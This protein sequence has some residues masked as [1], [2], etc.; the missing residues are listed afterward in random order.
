VSD[1]ERLAS[2]VETGLLDTAAEETFDRYTR[3]ATQL[4]NTPVS[5]VSLVDSDRQFFKSQVGLSEPWATARETPLSHSICKH[6]VERREPLLVE[7]T[8]SDP[9]F[10][11]NLAVSEL[12]VISYAGMPLTLKD[13][14]TIGTLCA[15]GPIPRRWTEED[16]GFLRDLATSLVSEIELRGEL[17]KRDRLQREMEGWL[18]FDRVLVEVSTRFIDTPPESIRSV[19]VS[20]LED[21]VR[22]FGGGGAFL[23]LEPLEGAGAREL[24]T[25]LMPDQ[26]QLPATG[27]REETE[28][29]L[30]ERLRR[31]ETVAIEDPGTLPPD[32]AGLRATLERRGTGAV[33]W[34]PVQRA[35]V[36]R[37]VLTLELRE[38]GQWAEHQL[39]LLRVFAERAYGAIRR[40][41]A[42]IE[43]AS[44]RA[45]AEA[46]MRAKERF[47]ANMSHELRTPLNAVIGVSQ[48]LTDTELDERQGDYLRAITHSARLLLALVNDLLDLARVDSGRIEFERVAFDFER[49]LRDAIAPFGYEAQRRGL[50]LDVSVGS[51]V[52]RVLV[53]DPV[54]L[55]QILMNLVGNALKFT[56]EGGIAVAVEVVGIGEADATLRLEV[57]D[58]GIGIASDKLGDI[59][60]A[61]SQEKSET[62]RLFGG[63]GLGLTLVR[64]L[65]EAQGG[66]VEVRSEVGRGTTFVAELAFGLGIS[67]DLPDPVAEEVV[68]LRGARILVVE[69][70]EINR[71]VTR[72]TLLSAGAQVECAEDGEE[73][74]SLLRALRFDLVLMD[75]Q[76]PNVDGYE[77]AWRIR[78]ELGRHA[79]EL[80]ILAL[81]ASAADSERRKVAAAGMDDLILKPCDPM[82]LKRKVAAHLSRRVPS[83][84]APY[85]ASDVIDL[86]R[87]EASTLGDPAFTRDLVEIFDRTTPP[88]LRE[89]GEAIS[90]GR[91]GDAAALAHKLKAA[92]G[93]IGAVKLQAEA[94]RLESAGARGEAPGLE[95]IDSLGR[96]YA[97]ASEALRDL[98]STRREG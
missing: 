83:T 67:P 32:A 69:D 96:L 30:A 60:E 74:I 71:M 56:R 15:I 16:V 59:F 57:T 43:L 1:R 14:Q 86:S 2:L 9:E 49:T 42:E 68:D 64:Q 36:L 41:A 80:P 35:G 79:S 37:A 82:L 65:V 85:S 94:D 78:T 29:W 95:N 61:F 90:D 50:S 47:L 84:E 34:I 98:V 66:T 3:L 77:A 21:L 93:V 4:L 22:A 70:S 75:L 76:M 20:A 63:T 17:K 72:Q 31:L 7:D 44:A 53:G 89:I 87:F 92:A 55:N 52:P 11:D 24:Y 19:A 48:L 5:L 6:A 40:A 73:A 97:E 13:G 81:T 23:T 18:A 51:A 39:L 46:S 58:T 25:S 12:D 38:P 33:V 27:D 28:P 62:A 10:R 45:M 8:R 54:R 88:L 91:Q 26:G